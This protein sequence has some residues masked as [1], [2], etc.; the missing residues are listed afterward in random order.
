V[1]TRFD[2]SR[3]NLLLETK[4]AAIRRT[5][6]FVAAEPEILQPNTKQQAQQKNVME[7]FLR[8]QKIRIVLLRRLDLHT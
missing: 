7:S 8:I 2:P 4:T 3:I 5:K 6:S 1:Q